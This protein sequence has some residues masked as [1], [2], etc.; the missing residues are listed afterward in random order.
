MKIHKKAH[1][2]ILKNFPWG[3]EI[4]NVEIKFILYL[5]NVDTSQ[6]HVW[7]LNLFPSLGAIFHTS[8]PG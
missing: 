4:L 1:K 7:I 5:I 8:L 6:N 2:V 3:P